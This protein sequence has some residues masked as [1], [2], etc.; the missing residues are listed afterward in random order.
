MQE[1]FEK[2]VSWLFNDKNKK[3][4]MLIFHSSATQIKFLTQQW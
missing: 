4:N 2:V 3:A 1:K